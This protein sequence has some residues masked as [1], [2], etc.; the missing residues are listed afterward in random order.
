M[1]SPLFV[2]GEQKRISKRA[3]HVHERYTRAAL[4]SLR[5]LPEDVLESNTADLYFS[6]FPIS[7]LHEYRCLDPSPWPAERIRGTKMK[8]LKVVEWNNVLRN[9]V[10]GHQRKAIQDLRGT[11]RN[12]RNQYV[13]HTLHWQKVAKAA[14]A[15]AN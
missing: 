1:N 12:P 9:V 14:A 3:L 13:K 8:H 10:P 5:C 6:P 7:F 4:V 11:H 2:R 15:E